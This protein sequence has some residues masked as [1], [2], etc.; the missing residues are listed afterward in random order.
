MTIRTMAMVTRIKA[1]G[2]R[3]GAAATKVM[4]VTKVTMRM[5][6]GDGD[7]LGDMAQDNGSG[8]RWERLGRG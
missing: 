6:L 8:S 4:T 5:T 2:N 1:T 3:N 7:N